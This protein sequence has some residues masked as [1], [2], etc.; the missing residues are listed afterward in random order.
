MGVY[1][2]LPTSLYADEDSGMGVY[3]EVATS[4]QMKS[5][6]WCIIT[7][8]NRYAD[9]L[10]EMGVCLQLAISTQMNSHRWVYPAVHKATCFPGGGVVLTF[11]IH[12]QLLSIA[13]FPHVEEVMGLGC[14]G[15]LVDA[16]GSM[17]PQMCIVHLTHATYY[18]R[19]HTYSNL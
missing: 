12:H 15:E 6:T 19:A 14:H 11:F 9:E 13:I 1:L 8:G 16:W 2:Q 17:R 10:S 18:L 4:T 3:F 5:P 7:I